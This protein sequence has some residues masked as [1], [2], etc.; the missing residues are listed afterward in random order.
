VR[1]AA[2]LALLLASACSS[3]AGTAEPGPSVCDVRFAAP[4]G[5]APLT[6]FEERYPDRIGVRLGFRD[7]ALRELHVFAGIPG[8]FGE[9]LPDAGALALTEDREGVLLGEGKVWVVTWNEGDRCDPRAVLGNGF[10][11]DRFVRTLAEAGVAET[12]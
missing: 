4:S 8:E 5:F 11:R 10:S 1:R 9:G 7:P 6:P 12:T 2:A 3:G